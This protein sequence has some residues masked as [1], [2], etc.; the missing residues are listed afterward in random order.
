MTAAAASATALTIKISHSWLAALDN[1][2][3]YH[4]LLS[5][6]EWAVLVLALGAVCAVAWPLFAAQRTVRERSAPPS[7]QKNL[8]TPQSEKNNVR[9]PRPD[10]ARLRLA[11]SIS[12]ELRTPLNAVIGFS[13]MMNSEAFG[14][15]GH[16]K[17]AEYC[18]HIT[19]SSQILL[20]TVE[21]LLALNDDLSETGL[22]CVPVPLADVLEIAWQDDAPTLFDAHQSTQLDV[23]GETQ[24]EAAADPTLLQHAIR[25]LVSTLKTHARAGTTVSVALEQD[26]DCAR[27][28]FTTPIDPKTCIETAPLIASTSLS[29]QSALASR[30]TLSETTARV[31]IETMKGR[32]EVR[33]RSD[34]ATPYDDTL[35]EMICELPTPANDA[36]ADFKAA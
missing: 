24:L 17:Y 14:A 12:H 28:V 20:R 9:L 10:D 23:T 29:G 5:I 4:Q 33:E 11:Q 21:D 30:D 26:T 18:S 15:L 32:L 22:A 36:T 2:A 31:L 25:N 8:L 27:L 35:L 7:P 19:D 1:A 13:S 34:E 6:F 16:P 3:L